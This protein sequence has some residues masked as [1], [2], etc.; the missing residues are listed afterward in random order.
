MAQ[1]PFPSSRPP[2][3]FCYFP[4]KTGAKR[5]RVRLIPALLV[6][7]TVLWLLATITF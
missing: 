3:R 4:E 2:W 6:V 1:P 5:V 7:G